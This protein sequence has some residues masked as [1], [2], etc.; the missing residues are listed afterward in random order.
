MA[1]LTTRPPFVAADP[2]R[3]ETGGASA[4]IDTGIEYTYLEDERKQG[5]SEKDARSGPIGMGFRVPMIIAS[6][7]TRGGWV[8]SQLFDHTST[9]MFLEHFVQHK[10]GKPVKEENISTWRRAISGDLTSAF[11]SSPEKDRA[12]DYL[13]RDK[14]VL[15]IQE[16]RDKEIPSNYKKLDA[17]EIKEFNRDPSSFSLRLPSGTWDSTL[18]RAALRAICRRSARCRMAANSN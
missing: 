2:K 10:Y 12:L 7:W 18:L 13:D 14:F 4:G 5:V 6:P 11:R 16:A 1:I 9:L 15:S 8:N 17:V 3:P